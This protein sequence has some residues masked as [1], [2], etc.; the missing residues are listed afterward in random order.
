MG[1]LVQALRAGGCRALSDVSLRALA[2]ARPPLEVLHVADLS[3]LSDAALAL[4]LA[5]AAGTLREAHLPRTLAGECAL[6]ALA[7][8]G[9]GGLRVLDLS[10]CPHLH[11]GLLLPVVLP[12]PTRRPPPPPHHALMLLSAS[13]V[14]ALLTV[15]VTAPFASP[16]PD[17]AGDEE[18]RV[19]QLAATGGSLDA[20]ALS[21]SSGVTDETLRGL[22]EHAPGLRRLL[23][24]RCTG[25]TD[26]GLTAALGKLRALEELDAS[27][28]RALTDTTARALLRGRQPWLRALDLRGCPLSAALRDDLAKL[29]GDRRPREL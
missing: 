2:A 8:G 23:V 15:P 13:L 22:G 12:H 14:L 25:L 26:A 28:N 24:D 29:V 18:A 1:V 16:C 19:S 3:D 17:T 4:T 6:A 27:G 11:D 10:G 5:A 21:G 9:A 20:L 7:G